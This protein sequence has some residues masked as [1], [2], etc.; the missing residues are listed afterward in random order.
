MSASMSDCRAKSACHVNKYM[1]A[2]L[3]KEKGEGAVYMNMRGGECEVEGEDV[4]RFLTTCP[5]S[6]CLIVHEC[7]HFT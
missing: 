7:F 2:A 6:L 1:L 5:Y 3:C 4:G